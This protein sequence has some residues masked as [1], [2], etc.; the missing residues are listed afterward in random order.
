MLEF[1]LAVLQWKVWCGTFEVNVRSGLSNYCSSLACRDLWSRLRGAVASQ[2]AGKGKWKGSQSK[3]NSKNKDYKENT[4]RS[5]LSLLEC[6]PG[7]LKAQHQP[8]PNLLFSATAIWAWCSNREDSW[9][10]IFVLILQDKLFLFFY[11]SKCL[12]YVGHEVGPE[13]SVILKM[14]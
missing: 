14:C 3:K 1:G 10:N 8:L 4:K 5:I 7:S 6:H 2:K 11:D 12:K 13:A 9:E